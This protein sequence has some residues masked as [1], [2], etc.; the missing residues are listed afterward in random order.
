[1]AFRKVDTSKLSSYQ[2]PGVFTRI[3]P[4]VEAALPGDSEV[5]ERIKGCVSFCHLLGKDEH[6]SDSAL[7]PKERRKF[8]RAALAEFASIDEA[9][10]I[11]KDR[12]CSPLRRESWT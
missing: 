1:M 6:L 11:D 10:K 7:E 5:L 12:V 9:A 2:S 3:D 4:A 8:L